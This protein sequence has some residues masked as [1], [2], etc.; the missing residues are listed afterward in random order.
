MLLRMLRPL[1]V[2][3]AFIAIAQT[4]PAQTKVAVINLQKAVFDSAEIKKADAD[5]PARFKK[6]Q[7]ELDQL[8][9][10]IAGIAQ[11]LQNSNAKLTPQQE[12]DLQAQGTRKQR[13]LQRKQDDLQQE[14]QSYRNEILTKS[15]QKMNDV[16]KKIAEEKGLDV[17]VDTST[18][19]YFKPA[20]DITA[21]ATTAYDKAYPAAAPAASK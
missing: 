5:M 21:E 3:S 1:V 6:Q 14:A 10:E 17:V 9:K 16:V 12:A 15:S 19:V 20:L 4:A 8:Q 7:D 18:T 13:D 11:Q 2:C